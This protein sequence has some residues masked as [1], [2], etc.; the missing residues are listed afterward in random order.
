MF[1]FLKDSQASLHVDTTYKEPLFSGSSNKLTNIDTSFFKKD[2]STPGGDD[3]YPSTLL[4]AYDLSSSGSNA[5]PI[6][7]TNISSR[8]ALVQRKDVDQLEEEASLEVWPSQERNHNTGHLRRGCRRIRSQV[9]IEKR[10]KNFCI[11]D[12]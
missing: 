8:S 3:S 10:K 1:T 12:N 6:S 5:T 2:L 9:S 11:K 4:S 7:A